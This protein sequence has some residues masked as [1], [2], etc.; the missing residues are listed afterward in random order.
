VAADSYGLA[1]Q[2][3]PAEPNEADYQ[4]F[5]DA[6]MDD[7]RGRWFLAE[8]GRRNRNADTGVLLKALNRVEVLVRLGTP[9]VL[10]RLRQELRAIVALI[11]QG[12]ADAAGDTNASRGE[13]LLM[14]LDQVERRIGAMIGESA[15]DT[16][17]SSDA[18][19]AHLAVVPAPAPV[20]AESETPAA[21]AISAAMMPPVAWAAG[22]ATVA[23]GNV[24]APT[25][26]HAAAAETAFTEMAPADIAPS[27]PGNENEP[28][29]LA[30]ES[31]PEIPAEPVLRDWMTAPAEPI[32]VAFGD[33]HD[34]TPQLL[35]TAQDFDLS[36]FDLPAAEDL[37][38]QEQ[39][40]ES[41]RVLTQDAVQKTSQEIVQETVQ[42][43]V[44]GLA[45][46]QAY[47]PFEVE[48]PAETPDQ[49]AAT[50]H[51]IE[52]QPSSPA[53][54]R[55]SEEAANSTPPPEAAA[56]ANNAVTDE[57]E[58]A[59][60]EIAVAITATT[61]EERIAAANSLPALAAL[62]EEER[63]ALFT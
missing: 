15:G 35:K 37:Q 23:A 55:I 58:K 36:A 16:E 30:A 38:P 48:P 56:A 49:P 25:T 47:V 29:M 11:R 20:S 53:A 43:P 63:L 34:V 41:A 28:A 57:M 18:P 32:A 40:S 61:I 52:P 19:R 50:V 13:K 54:I 2:A 44:T 7:E 9:D 1:R 24:A 26:A 46:E 5:Y 12:C 22:E 33:A 62:S 21:S 8:Y 45:A 39:A 3:E 14:L 31:T 27:P 10:E 6:L 59:M 51:V 42:E 4:A 60:A 17:V